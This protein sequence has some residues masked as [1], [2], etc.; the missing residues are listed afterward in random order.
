MWEVPAKAHGVS[1]EGEENVLKLVSG[2]AF[3][4]L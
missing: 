4:S 1:F 2:D 3:T